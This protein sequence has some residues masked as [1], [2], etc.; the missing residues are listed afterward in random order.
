MFIELQIK[1]FPDPVV[2][3]SSA[4][5]NTGIHTSLL[6]SGFQKAPLLCVSLPTHRLCWLSV[7]VLWRWWSGCSGSKSQHASLS[8]LVELAGS[9]SLTRD[10]TWPPTSAVWSPTHWTTGEVP[11]LACSCHSSYSWNVGIPRFLPS[12]QFLLYACHHFSH[13]LKPVYTSGAK[14]P[15]GHLQ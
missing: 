12:D 14:A 15:V 4:L 9:S 7:L 11:V 2:I 5:L 10:Q 13:H 3:T 8:I 1:G 6:N